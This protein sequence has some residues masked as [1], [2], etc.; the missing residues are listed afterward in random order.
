MKL[1]LTVKNKIINASEKM[2]LLKLIKSQLADWRFEL[3][4]WPFGQKVLG[5][6]LCGTLG[7]VIKANS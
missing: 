6:Q 7:F 4:I 5:E 2:S 3:A 1:K